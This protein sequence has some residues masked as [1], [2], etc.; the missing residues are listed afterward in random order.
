MSSIILKKAVQYSRPIRHKAVLERYDRITLSGKCLIQIEP[1]NA[2]NRRVKGSLIKRVWESQLHNQMMSSKNW[3]LIP[4]G[5]IPASGTYVIWEEDYDRLVKLSTRM[6]PEP[7]A[8]INEQLRDDDLVVYAFK[9]DQLIF[10]E[11]YPCNST[12]AERDYLRLVADPTIT[13]VRMEEVG[14]V[15]IV[16]RQRQTA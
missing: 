12:E 15:S 8:L 9:G 6:V 10:L 13:Q 11:K 4:Q 2:W 14:E 1:C 7:Q 3:R 16:G 5:V